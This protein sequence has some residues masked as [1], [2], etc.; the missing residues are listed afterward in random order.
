MERENG[1]GLAGTAERMQSTDH[2]HTYAERGKIDEADF[3]TARDNDLND[4]DPIGK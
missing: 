3:V 2:M 4:E 1:N